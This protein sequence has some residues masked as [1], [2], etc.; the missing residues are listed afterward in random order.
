LRP[1]R[2]CTP[3]A[4]DRGRLNGA[5]CKRPDPPCHAEPARAAPHHRVWRAPLSQCARGLGKFLWTVR[6]TI[7]WL[8]FVEPSVSANIASPAYFFPNRYPVTPQRQL[9]GLGT[10]YPDTRLGPPALLVTQCHL[11]T[12]A[13][14]QKRLLFD[15]LIGAL[16]Q[17]GVG[18]P[19]SSPYAGFASRF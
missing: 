6:K 19:P 9:A 7:P 1:R 11:L 17:C 5:F 8:A 13:A 2:K 14:Q 10:R 12:H 18:Q 15:H 16:A 4:F 3:H